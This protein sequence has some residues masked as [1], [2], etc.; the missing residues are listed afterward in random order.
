MRAEPGGQ[1]HH[2]DGCDR[3]MNAAKL[4]YT[5]GAAVLLAAG[6][7]CACADVCGTHLH[8]A[9]WDAQCVDQ[10]LR[11]GRHRRHQAAHIVRHHASHLRSTHTHTRTNSGAGFQC[12][13]SLGMLF[14][15]PWRC[16][17]GAGWRQAA[18]SH[19][20]TV[21]HTANASELLCLQRMFPRANTLTQ[22]T[23]CV[24]SIRPSQCSP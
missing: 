21:H 18:R 5:Q 20:P 16:C 8:Q 22:V 10:L 4:L 12:W 23:T 13:F 19:Q 3:M 11:V 17:L 9:V 15:C 2:N 7:P 1:R 6:A 24:C 14:C